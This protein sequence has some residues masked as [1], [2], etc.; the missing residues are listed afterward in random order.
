MPELRKS[1]FH[2]AY[3]PNNDV[4]I[5][6]MLT[7]M[8]GLMTTTISIFVRGSFNNKRR[9]IIALIDK[10]HNNKDLNRLR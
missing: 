5:I 6:V 4:T 7:M 3:Q 2:V 9:E 8:M 1:L 10:G